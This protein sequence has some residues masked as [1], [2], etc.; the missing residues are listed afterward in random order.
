MGEPEEV[1]KER[2]ELLTPY[3]INNDTMKIID[4]PNVKFMHCLPSFHNR[5]TTIGKDIYQEFSLD[6]MEVTEKVFES[7]ASIVFD[8]AENKVHTLK[9]VMVA[10]LGSYSLKVIIMIRP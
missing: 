8:D 9:A 10:N 6:G 5:E 2:I 3:Q 4:N 7:E 1:W